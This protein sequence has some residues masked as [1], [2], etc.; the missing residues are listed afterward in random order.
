MKKA[1]I[2]INT[3]ILIVIA[4]IVLIIIVAL[5]YNAAEGGGKTA[6]AC[7]NVDGG[8]CE[9]GDRCDSQYFVEYPLGSKGCGEGYVCCR[10]K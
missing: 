5:V 4:L 1:E 6:F 7:E 8:F 9:P 2:S 3:I 10:P